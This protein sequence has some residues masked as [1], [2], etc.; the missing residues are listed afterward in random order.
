MKVRVV[1]VKEKTIIKS[2][3]IMRGSI[4]KNSMTK[5]TEQ[6]VLFPNKTVKVWIEI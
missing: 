2:Y 5:T 6:G 1:L 4:T 3:I